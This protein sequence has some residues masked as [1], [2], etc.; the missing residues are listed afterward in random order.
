[1]SCRTT[2]PKEAVL[3]ATR[4]DAVRMASLFTLTCVCNVTPCSSHNQRSEHSEWAAD[5]SS[6]WGCLIIYGC[7]LLLG[8]LKLNIPIKE[9][10]P[11]LLA[12]YTFTSEYP[13]KTPSLTLSYKLIDFNLKEFSR[14]WRVKK[15]SHKNTR[16]R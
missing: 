10:F 11:S 12:L 15:K 7:R 3:T 6:V 1:M 8:S 14:H 4:K 9:W 13:A 2:Q 16:K 5:F